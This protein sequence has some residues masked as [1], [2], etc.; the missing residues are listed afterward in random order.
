[1]PD[2]NK[3][4]P[5]AKQQANRATKGERE[6]KDSKARKK[7]RQTLNHERNTQQPR[8]IKQRGGCT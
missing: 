7:E 6:R 5:T 2:E 4:T 8:R 1:M 3:I